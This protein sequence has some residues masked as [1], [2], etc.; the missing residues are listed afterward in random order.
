MANGSEQFDFVIIGAGSAGCVLANRLSEKPDNRVCVIE[1]GP[2]DV[3]PVIHM[4]S[5]FLV[6]LLTRG[7]NWGF[8]TV[9]QPGL[10][11]RVGYQPRGKTLGGSSSI[12]AMVYIRGQREDYDRWAALGNAGWSYDDVLPYFKK[13]EH[14]EVGTSEFHGQNGPL[15]VTS[16]RAPNPILQHFYDASRELQLPINEDFNGASQEG[17][18]PYHVT[19]KQGKRNSTAAAYLHPVENRPNLAVKTKARVARISFDGK[20]ATGVVIRQGKEEKFLSAARGVIVSAGAFQS[21]QVLMLSGIGP[22]DHLRANGISVVHDLPSV[23][24]NLH[25]HPDYVLSYKSP[26]K[27]TV[28]FSP[29]GI[30]NLIKGYYTYVSKKDGPLTSNMAEAG[31][32]LKTTPEVATPDIQLHFVPA[33]VDDHGRK[34]HTTHGFSCHVCVLRPKS[35]GRV[36]LSGVD[37]MAAPVID[38]NFLSA[39]EDM[40]T[41][42]RGFK[43]TRRIMESPAMNAIR[44]EAL[45]I[46]NVHTDE[47]IEREIR[48]RTDTVY[49]PVGTCKMGTDD[50]AV[51]DPSLKVRGI[52]NLHVVDAS[53]MPEVVSGN[54]NAPTIMIAEKAADMI[55]AA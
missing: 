19:Q 49:H 44:G 37:P 34:L 5:G 16:L 35:R 48:N 21:P 26:S 41:M 31:G 25:D 18:G 29:Q 1:A 7:H 47:E 39:P 10:N 54:T 40:E 32:F 17:C 36:T 8:E 55:Q 23:G 9:P 2:R 33:L 15:N 22:S 11:G 24:E 20:K 43:L 30:W 52:D 38:P 46:G 51:V 4:P 42:M 3:N 28:G 14:F 13:A 6:S 50:S 53:I 45:Y 12:N 27:E